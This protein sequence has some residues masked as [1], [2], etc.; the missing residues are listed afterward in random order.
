MERH[1]PERFPFVLLHLPG[2]GGIWT[3]REPWRCQGREGNAREGH[4]GGPGQGS[5]GTS[6]ARAQMYANMRL[7]ANRFPFVLLNLSGGGGMQIWQVV[8]RLRRTEGPA[9]QRRLRR[10]LE[11]VFGVRAGVSSLNLSRSS[12]PARAVSGSVT[13]A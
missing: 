13:Q 2:G 1:L 5:P 7:R 6:P 10:G 3:W 8:L 11:G 12:F 9:C 4:Q